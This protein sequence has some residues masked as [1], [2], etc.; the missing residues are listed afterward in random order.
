MWITSVYSVLIT[1]LF[2]SEWLWLHGC[3]FFCVVFHLLLFKNNCKVYVITYIHIN[4]H[5]YFWMLW[6]GMNKECIS[7]QEI[8]VYIYIIYIPVNM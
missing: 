1:F 5:T 8:C 6:Y 2:L 7:H 4:V 3:I